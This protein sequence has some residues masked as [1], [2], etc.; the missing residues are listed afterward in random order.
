MTKMMLPF[1][2]D[3]HLP[4]L[5]HPRCHRREQFK[6]AFKCFF[7]SS[8]S[9]PSSSH[10]FPLHRAIALCLSVL[11]TSSHSS[12]PELGTGVTTHSGMMPPLLPPP[13]LLSLPI[14]H[15]VPQMTAASAH[16]HFHLCIPAGRQHA[17]RS[18][19]TPACWFL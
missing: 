11:I 6:Q 17:E 2:F 3:T 16:S 14:I 18:A 9:F 19:G 8:P 15:H 7:S 12:C 10:T 5:P 1:H 13:P 4:F